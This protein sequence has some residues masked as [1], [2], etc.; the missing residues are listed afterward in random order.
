MCSRLIFEF[1]FK[2]LK[3]ASSRSSLYK[4]NKGSSTEGTT[5][6]NASSSVPTTNFCLGPHAVHTVL[7][8]RLDLGRR[9]T[10]YGNR[11]QALSPSKELAAQIPVSI[12]S[13][14]GAM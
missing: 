12:Q 10:L 2:I 9:H 5:E 4:T 14:A 8:C 1:Y 7:L 11:S 13:D 6:K 3:S